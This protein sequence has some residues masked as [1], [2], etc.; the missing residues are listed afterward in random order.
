[1]N[2]KI[3]TSLAFASLVLS[4]VVAQASVTFS[5]TALVKVPNISTGDVA[6]F[7]IDENN[8]GFGNLGSINPNTSL[9]ES[10]TIYEGTSFTIGSDN[11][12]S[13]F[14]IVGTKTATGSATVSVNGTFSGVSLGSGVDTGDKFAIIVF[15]TSTTA[16]VAGDTYRIFT[17]PTW[18]VPSDGFTVTYSNT[19]TGAFAQ[20][21]ASAVAAFTKTIAA[22]QAVPEPS[23]FAALAGFAVLGFAASRRRRA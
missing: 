8:A 11:L 2:H 12:G 22:A 7:I 6:Y 16:G 5:G 15:E 4:G 21:G 13:G 18:V 3:K 9:F 1:M 14:T 19:T 20:L 10:G 17:D 23:S